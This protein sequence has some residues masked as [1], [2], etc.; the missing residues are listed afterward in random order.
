MK[1]RKSLSILA[2]SALCASQLL[3]ATNSPATRG[4]PV[5]PSATSRSATNAPTPKGIVVAP[6]QERAQSTNLNSQLEAIL[7]LAW[8]GGPSQL[9]AVIETDD[10]TLTIAIMVRDAFTEG[11]RERGWWGDAWKILRF[12]FGSSNDNRTVVV[13]GVSPAR[14]KFGN[15]TFSIIGEVRMTRSD[16]D[17][18]NAKNFVAD[19][20]KNWGTFKM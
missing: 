6:P 19:D 12:M 3:A 13:W 17:R 7:G 2:I 8:S 20:L 1:A 10:G 18:I 11:S 9:A 4:V 15:D 16:Y 5:K 14:D